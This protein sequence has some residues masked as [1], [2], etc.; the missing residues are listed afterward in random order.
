M[1]TLQAVL[2]ASTLAISV[3]ASAHNNTANF[4]SY[5]HSGVAA[6]LGKNMLAVAYYAPH[7]KYTAG[8]EVN[9]YKSIKVHTASAVNGPISAA[10]FAR[11]NKPLTDRTVLGVGFMYATNLGNAKKYASFTRFMVAPYFALEYAATHHV[12]IGASFR[13]VTYSSVRTTLD[14]QTTKTWEF[15]TGGSLQ[16]SYIF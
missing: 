13:P 4:D 2:A 7:H 8:I 11:Y 3:A 1:K 14:T 5:H 9:P 6:Q 10:A 15:I 16:I 12:L